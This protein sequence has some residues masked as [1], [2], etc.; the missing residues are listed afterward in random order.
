MAVRLDVVASGG[1]LLSRRVFI[2]G[3]GL[4]LRSLCWFLAFFVGLFGGLLAR[5]FR[6][7]LERGILILMRRSTRIRFGNRM[8][9]VFLWRRRLMLMVLLLFVY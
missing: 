9:C 2:L 7:L 5:L 6:R 3:S 8:L 1:R 4:Y